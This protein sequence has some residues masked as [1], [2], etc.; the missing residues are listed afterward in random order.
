MKP[1]QEKLFLDEQGVR[2]TKT[3]LM[4]PGHSVEFRKILSVSLHPKAASLLEKL[5]QRTTFQLMVT[6]NADKAPVS[7][8]ETQDA[9]LMERIQQAMNKA[10]NAAGGTTNRLDP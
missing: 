4:L 9:V 2:I 8:F 5:M 7:V 6:T 1:P 3:H 10:A